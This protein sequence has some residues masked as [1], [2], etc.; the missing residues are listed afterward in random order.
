MNMNKNL[1]IIMPNYPSTTNNLAYT[2]TP[3][4]KGDTDDIVG[5]GFFYV[6]KL[7]KRYLVTCKHVIKE[8]D[9][10]NYTTEEALDEKLY[11]FMTIKV[12]KMDKDNVV[13]SACIVK[14]NI[15]AVKYHPKYDIAVIP[16]KSLMATCH[17]L[18]S[19]KLSFI[20]EKWM[21]NN[22]YMMNKMTFME[23]IIMLGYPD[24]KYDS[25]N[26]FP[27]FKSGTTASHPC[28]DFQIPAYQIDNDHVYD[29]DGCTNISNYRGDS[30]APIFILSDGMRSLP[31]GGS[32]INTGDD[33][34]FIGVHFSSVHPRNESN[35]STEMQLGRYVKSY[36]SLIDVDTWSHN[37]PP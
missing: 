36:Y 22:D 9:S 27:I 28:L 32:V 35:E 17:C 10:R 29:R 14:F 13:N 30:G 21:Q 19:H 7:N 16:I 1:N 23:N 8:H 33:P 26:N 4:M 37:A 6:S 18:Y 25:H 3:I 24:G 20:L 11:D 12:H 15:D 31:K 34:F 5:T 2:T